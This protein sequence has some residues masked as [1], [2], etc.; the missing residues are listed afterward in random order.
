LK[1]I[2]VVFGARIDLADTLDHFAERYTSPIV[3]DRNLLFLLIELNINFIAVVHD[4]FIDRIVNDFL[5][6]HIDPVICMGAISQP[7]DIHPGSEPDV[8]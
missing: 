6:H 8:C 3:A 2:V 1:H 7:A 5:E 4:E